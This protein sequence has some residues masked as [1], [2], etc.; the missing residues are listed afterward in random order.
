MTSSPLSAGGAM[1]ILDSILKGMTCEW[2]WSLPQHVA[3]SQ[4]MSFWSCC[5][6]TEPNWSDGSLPTQEILSK[7]RNIPNRLYIMPRGTVGEERLWCIMH[8]VF[9][10]IH[11]AVKGIFML[12]RMSIIQFCLC[13]LMLPSNLDLQ[14]LVP[15]STSFL[16]HSCWHQTTQKAIW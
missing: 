15:I 1:D 7:I 5:E 2:W 9:T 16:L 8:L 14:A 13:C 4:M 11:T 12:P 10:D 3:S 6:L